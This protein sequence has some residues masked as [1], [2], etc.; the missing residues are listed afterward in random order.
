MR[1]T[2]PWEP[3]R[4][5]GLNTI[6]ISIAHHSPPQNPM[7]G[8]DYGSPAA[9]I[10]KI[11]SMVSDLDLPPCGTGYL[12]DWGLPLIEGVFPGY[13]SASRLNAERIA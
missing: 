2:L 12:T 7:R 3:G 11:R 5:F 1:F 13:V 10:K 4:E 8:T 9:K 6:P